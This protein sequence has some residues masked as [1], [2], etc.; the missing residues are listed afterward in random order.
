MDTSK[1]TKELPMTVPDVSLMV[2]K[3]TKRLNQSCSSDC[4]SCLLSPWVNYQPVTAKIKTQTKPNPSITRSDPLGKMSSVTTTNIRC[5]LRGTFRRETEYQFSTAPPPSSISRPFAR[6][7]EFYF[8]S[9]LQS[10][11]LLC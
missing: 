6:I 5:L 3:T 8:R 11:I 2:I 9:N 10:S 7:H 1:R 4:Q